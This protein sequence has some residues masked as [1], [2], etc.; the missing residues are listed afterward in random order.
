M[1][2]VDFSTVSNSPPSSTSLSSTPTS[3]AD[4]IVMTV[5]QY[6]ILSLFAGQLED[7]DQRELVIEMLV[8]VCVIDTE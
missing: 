3:Q 7:V 5:L 8:K 6:S 2:G 1:L 4:C